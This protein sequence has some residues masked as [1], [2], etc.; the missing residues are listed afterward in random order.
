MIWVF[1]VISDHFSIGHTHFPTQSHAHML[2]FRLCHACLD[3]RRVLLIC[4]KSGH[5]NTTFTNELQHMLLWMVGRRIGSAYYG[6]EKQHRF[7][8][9]V[10]LETLFA[11]SGKLAQTIIL[12]P[13]NLLRAMILESRKKGGNNCSWKSATWSVRF[14]GTNVLKTCR[15][16][17]RW[18]NGRGLM[19]CDWISHYIPLSFSF[20]EILYVSIITELIQSLM[21]LSTYTV[22]FR[23]FLMASWSIKNNAMSN[24]VS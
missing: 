9:C 19:G 11:V 14:V 10:F 7:H 18:G 21:H 23:H 13:R 3:F 6:V 12:W 8:T 16:D 22:G 5:V 17:F 1:D 15:R 24:T 20:P 4:R 2:Y